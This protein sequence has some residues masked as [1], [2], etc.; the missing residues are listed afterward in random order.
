MA[1]NLNSV[2]YC[3]YI[4]DKITC[5]SCKNEFEATL[6]KQTL[7]GVDIYYIQCPNCDERKFSYCAD[8]AI[9]DR[10]KKTGV[11]HRR[12]G[13]PKR[14]AD[15]RLKDMNKYKKMREENRRLMREAVSTY[16]HL[17]QEVI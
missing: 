14:P 2:D 17:I 1:A 10:L 4:M 7:K 3:F 8:K 13:D 12:S 5:A 15:K 16:Q 11:I 6:H 9:R